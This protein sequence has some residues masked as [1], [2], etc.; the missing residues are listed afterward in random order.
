MHNQASLADTACHFVPVV[1]IPSGLSHGCSFAAELTAPDGLIPSGLIDVDG[2]GTEAG[3]T[4]DGMTEDS[5]DVKPIHSLL[6]GS[7]AADVLGLP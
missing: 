1:L 7:A 3:A 5:G 6:Y 4:D 2:S